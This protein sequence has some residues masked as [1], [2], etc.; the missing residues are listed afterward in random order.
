IIDRQNRS[1]FIP[2]EINTNLID[3]KLLKI[4][5]EFGLNTDTALSGQEVWNKYEEVIKNQDVDFVKNRIMLDK[6]QGLMS[7]FT[8]S[9]FPES[10]DA[11][12]LK[13]YGEEKYGYLFLESYSDV[14]SFE[15]GINTNVLQYSN[16]L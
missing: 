5:E 6:I 14:Y 7:Q 8:I 13:R 15:N 11:E 10:K 3:N 9:V 16:F 1:I 12:L 2:L 4:A